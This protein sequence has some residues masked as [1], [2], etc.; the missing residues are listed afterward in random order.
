MMG[1]RNGLILSDKI[2]TVYDMNSIIEQVKTRFSYVRISKRKG[3]WNIPNAFDIETSSFFQ[4]LENEQ[5]PQK[6]AIMYVWTASI[7]GFVIMGRT[8]YEFSLF[9]ENLVEGFKTDLDHRL[10][11]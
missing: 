6:V 1:F 9:I 3:F 5:D 10:I 11:I 4:L 2:Y 8:W 7:G